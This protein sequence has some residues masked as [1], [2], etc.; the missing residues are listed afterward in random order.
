M[1]VLAVGSLEVRLSLG[2]SLEVFT[3]WG[4][5]LSRAQRFG[6][7]VAAA[8]LALSILAGVAAQGPVEPRSAG[9]EVTVWRRVSNPSLL[10]VSTR[11]EGGSWRTQNTPLDMSEP[12][13]SGR[14]HQSNAVLVEVR[15]GDGATVGVE[16]TVW[17]RMSNPSLLY[18][19]TRPEGGTWRTLNTPLD[20]SS[21]SRTRRFHQSNAVLV[22]VPLPDRP[23]EAPAP[24]DRSHCSI[25]ERTAAKVIASTVQVVT[26]SGLGSAFY[27]GNSEFVTAAHVVEDN[28]PWITLRNTGFSV[29]ARLEGFYPFASGDIALLSASAAGMTALEGAGT[30]A[31]GAS[32]AVVGYPEGLGAGEDASITTGIVSRLFTL[33]GISYIQTDA[34]ANPGNSGGPLVD[35]CG[36][37]AGVISFAYRDTEGLHFAV[38]EPALGRLLEA[39]RSGQSPPPVERPPSGSTDANGPTWEQVNLFIDLV[40]KDWS[41]TVTALDSLVEQ[42]DIIIDYESLPSDRL[43]ESARNSRDLAQ[44]MVTTLEGLRSDPATRDRTASSYLESAVSYWAAGVEEEEE[45]ENYA[46]TKT[47]WA[48]VLR[49]RASQAEAYATFKSK[50]CNLWR[51]QGYSNAEEQCH[52]ADA[53]ERSAEEAT[54]EADERAAWEQIDAFIRRTSERREET[55][56]QIDGLD[57]SS[58]GYRRQQHDIWLGLASWLTDQRSDPVTA[59]PAVSRYLETAIA[60]QEALASAARVWE[61]HALDTLPALRAIATNMATSAAHQRAQCDLWRLQGYSNAE[62]VCERV[63]WWEEAAEEAAM[64]VTELGD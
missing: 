23:E 50:G 60:N 61:E 13:T 16:V 52:E 32:V 37:V 3:C 20:M 49:A 26:P 5:A 35:A 36:R 41:T 8:V 42:W 55:N 4:A 48:A 34:A 33:Q 9:V 14:F 51:L 30:L 53:A 7:A 31:P 47:T 56:S 15:L 38:G 11:P 6:T 24:A 10:Y 2:D 21:L 12:S 25:D 62:E 17:R 58:P 59:F 29:S 54:A 44:A 18:V 64:R 1:G 39:I 28:P 63:D 19:S 57:W 45:L 22:D 46:L 27:V 43:A 40:L